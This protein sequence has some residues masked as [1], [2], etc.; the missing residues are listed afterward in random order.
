[1]KRGILLTAGLSLALLLF[2]SWTY[3]RATAQPPSTGQKLV[4]TWEVTLRLPDCTCACQCPPGVGPN[5]L[6]RALHT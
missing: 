1:M 3:T 6:L 5:T 2:L 4:G